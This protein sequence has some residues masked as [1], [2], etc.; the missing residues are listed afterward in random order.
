M[1]WHQIGLALLAIG[2]AAL[3]SVVRMR[4]SISD[5]HAVAQPRIGDDPQ[6][7]PDDA[8]Q[9]LRAKVDRLRGDLHRIRTENNR[10]VRENDNLREINAELER[11]IAGRSTTA[12]QLDR[13]LLETWDHHTSPYHWIVY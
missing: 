5:L 2:L 1:T 10:L 6:R 11:S 4:K 12:D 7:L 9:A 8:T 3:I 13:E